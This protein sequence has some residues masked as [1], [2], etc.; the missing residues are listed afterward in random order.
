MR[1]TDYLVSERQYFRGPEA[2]LGGR[3]VKPNTGIDPGAVLLTRTWFQALRTFYT[4]VFETMASALRDDG[5][6]PNAHPTTCRIVANYTDTAG[7]TDHVSA[8]VIR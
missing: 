8:F 1:T 3:F 7:A 4:R 5:F 2:V 6:A